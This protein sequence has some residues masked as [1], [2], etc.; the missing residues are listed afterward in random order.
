MSHVRNYPGIN[1]TTT[2]PCWMLAEFF[3]HDLTDFCPAIP[4]L[5]VIN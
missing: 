1:K 2:M 3:C 5:L 4:A